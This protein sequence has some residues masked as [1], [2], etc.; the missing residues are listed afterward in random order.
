MN[1]KAPH[2]A[3]QILE[4][5]L[6]EN[7]RNRMNEV[8]ADRI[9]YLRLIVQDVHDPH[10]VSACLRS[11]EAFGIQNIHIVTLGESYTPTS[12]AKGAR[13]W[14]TIHKHETIED[15]VDHLKEKNFAIAA[16]MPPHSG[17]YTLSELS[18]ERPLAILFGNEHDGVS[19]S[20]QSHIDLSFTIPMHGMVESLNIS[21][22]AAIAMQRLSERVRVE[23]PDRYQVSYEDRIPIL[24]EWVYR[25]FKRNDRV[26]DRLRERNNKNN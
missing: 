9:G 18:L 8:I 13:H 6:T 21:V 1:P 16:G 26:L 5:E 23:Q 17:S 12:V 15:C 4:P 7:R 10:N 2:D 20:W 25:Q 22:S 24:N 19:E 14:L 11:A 3:W